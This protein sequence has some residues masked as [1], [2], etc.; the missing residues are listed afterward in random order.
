MKKMRISGQSRRGAL[1]AQE[2]PGNLTT[3]LNKTDL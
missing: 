3:D 1:H 2:G